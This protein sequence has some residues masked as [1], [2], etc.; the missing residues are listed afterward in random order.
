MKYLKILAAVIFN[1]ALA[2]S[3]MA[4][5]IDMLLDKLA[6]KDVISYGE[7]QQIKTE[8]AE[9]I[10]A[11]IAAGKHADAP[12]WVQSIMLKG[13]VRLR[14]QTER[15]DQDERRNRNRVRAKVGILANVTPNWKAGI[16]LATGGTDSRSTNQT[17]EDGFSKKGIMLD[18]AY[19]NYIPVSWLALWGG[20]YG[21]ENALWKTGDLLWDSDINVE[22]VNANIKYKVNSF[23][24]FINSGYWILDEFKDSGSSQTNNPADPYMI[25]VQPGIKYSFSKPNYIKVASHFYQF[26]HVKDEAVLPNSEGGNTTYTN[27]AGN[28]VLKYDYDSVGAD[29]EIGFAIPGGIPKLQWGAVFGE[30]IKNNNPDKRNE[31]SLG[32]IKLGEQKITEFGHI[33]ATYMYRHLEKDAWLDIFPDSDSYD[34]ETG[35]MGHEIILTVGLAKNVSLAFDWYDMRPTT[36][37]SRHKKLLQTDLLVK[38]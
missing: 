30:Y 8:S 24:F 19:M 20:K 22:G 2:L 12:S 25:M 27:G 1:C 14:N 37:N 5:E 35:I 4:G 17:L 11:D 13:D 34:G 33:Q 6:E 36:P 10:R 32:G 9:Q 16:G 28:T 7:A 31:G 23:K 15:K 18:Y 21:I 38:F 29:A 26:Q 3:V